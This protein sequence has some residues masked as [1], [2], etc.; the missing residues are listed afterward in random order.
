MSEIKITTSG[1]LHLD[2]DVV[3]RIEWLKPYVESDVAGIF[4]QD[5][6]FVNEWGERNDC[7]ACEEKVELLAALENAV[8]VKLKRTLAGVRKEALS[9]DGVLIASLDAVDAL[10]DELDFET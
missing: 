4:S 6:P 7:T 1:E 2:G 3:G 9:E 5:D 8:T 10:I